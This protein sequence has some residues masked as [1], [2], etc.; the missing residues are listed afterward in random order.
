[1]KAKGKNKISYAPKTKILP[2]PKRDNSAK[3]SIY[4]HCKDVG[5]FTIELYAFPNKTWVHDTGCGTHICNTS[6]GLRESRKLK[7]EALSLYMGNGMHAA[8]EAIES[9]DLILPSGLI[10]V[11]DNCHFAPTVTRGVVLI[12][13]LVNNSYIH[14]FTHYGISVSKD[15]VFYFNATPRDGIYEIDMHN[16]Y[17]NVSS[18][19]NVSNKR[20]NHS[21]GIVSQLTSPYTPQHNE[22]SERRNYT[23]L[24]MVSSMMNLTTLSK[25]FWGYALET[26]ARILN[27]LPTK[28]VDRTPYEIWH[29]KAPN[30]MV[31]EASE[32]HGLLKM[33]R[34]DKGLEIIQEEDTQPSKNTIKEHIE[35]APIKVEPQNVRVPI[36]RS[37]RIPQ[38]P[39]RYEYYVDIEE[40]ELGYLDKPPN[41]KAALVDPGSNKWLEAMN[42]EMQSMKHNQK[43]RMENSKNGY[44]SMIEKLDYRKSQG[45]KTPID[46]QRM[47]RVPYAL[48]I[49]SIMYAVRCTRPDVAFAQNLCSHFQQKPGELHWTAVKTI[50]KPMEMLCDNEPAL[51]TPYLQNEHYALWEVIEFGDSYEVPK[52]SAAIGSA[53]DGKKGRTVAI[54]TGDMQKRRNDVK[55]RTTLLLALPDEHQLRFS[56]Y[57]TAQE[58]WAAILKTFGGNEATRKT[59][60]NLLK[61]QYGNFKVEGKETLEQTFNRLHAIVS[62]LEFMDMEIEQ[63]DLNQKLLTSLAPEWLM[64]TI[65]WRNRSDLDTMSLDDLYN[66]LKIGNEEDNTTSVPT[67]STQV[68]PAGATVAL[69]SISLDT[70]CA[71]IASQSNGLQKALMAIDGVGW[72]WSYMQN[73]EEN[74]ALVADEEA[75]IEFALMAKTSTDNEVEGRLVKF[76]N[77][78]IKFCEKIKGLEFSVECKSNRIENLTNELET[79]KKEKEGLESKLTG[80]KSATKDLDNLIGSQSS[81]KIKKGLGYSVVPPSC[82]KSNPDDLQNSS[83]SASENRESTGSILSKPEI[84]FV[85][86]GDSPTVVK[87]DK[88]ETVRKPTVKYAELYRKT[89]KMSNVDHRR[90]WAKNNYTPKCRSPRIV[91]HKTGRPPIRTNRPTMN[92]AQPKRTSFYKPSHSYHKRP[93]Q[94]TLAVRSQFRGLRVPIVNRKFPAVNRKFPT[95]NLKFSTTDMGNKGKAVQGNSQ[96]NIDDKGYWDNG[97]SRHM[98][99]NISYLSGYEP[100]DG[101]FQ[102]PKFPARVYKV[103]K[104]MYGLHKA[105]RAWYGTLSKYLLTNGFQRGTI[106]QTLFIR[107][108]RGDFLLVQ[109]YVDDII[110]GS[111]NPQLCREFEALMHEKF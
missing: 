11:L 100:Y 54:T 34:S 55:A 47:Q 27:M 81:D 28:K 61:Q 42:M 12:S 66:H 64:H 92:A 109:V 87:T 82:L 110:F 108:H 106:D 62:Q 7:H 94:R 73:D 78:E 80:F 25:S 102:D 99:D 97:C 36:R 24:D 6:Q 105:P 44:T 10:I 69:A 53:S 79:L 29:G 60:K 20:A 86:P 16:L 90:T 40:Y 91:F 74:H 33:I 18:N 21:Y 70:T 39:D 45:A 104:A 9:F 3:D 51:A 89:S 41:Y 76:K 57:K 48:A 72:D 1:G 43:F 13:H 63:D 111:S 58:L 52:D 4:H 17:L 31:Q 107:R 103:E 38:V 96:I 83:S 67:A 77:Q 46:V 98:T 35:V 15:N 50:L 5:I 19:Y 59:K 101:G 85:K 71:Y 68:S 75:P 14:I 8:V 84:K 56:K 49:G 2:P 22:V 93:F 32:G 30:S 26:T 23:L 37:A 95:G 88:K 65:V